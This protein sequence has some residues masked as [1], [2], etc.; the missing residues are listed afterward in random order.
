MSKEK[1]TLKVVDLLGKV[2]ISEANTAQEGANLREIDLSGIA[3]GMY[4]L[5]FEREGAENQTM[6]IVVQ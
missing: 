1:Y 4:L 2:L 3:K 5:S 6:R